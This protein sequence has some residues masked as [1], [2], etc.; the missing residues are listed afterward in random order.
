MPSLNALRALDAVAR[1]GSF[2]RAAD[3]LHVSSPAVQQLVRLLEEA[4]GQP[5]VISRNR[6]LSLSEAA[7]SASPLLRSGFES[8]ASAVGE[9]RSYA[10]P[11]GIKV[12]VEPSFAAGWLLYR[13]SDFQLLHPD[14]DVFIEAS[15][16]LA[17]LDRDA[18]IAIRYKTSENSHYISQQLFEDET[19]AVCAPALL[20]TVAHALS[21]SGNKSQA[22]PLIHF[23]SPRNIALQPD[24][25]TWLASAQI[26]L[27]IPPKGLRFSDYNMVLQSAIAGQGLALVSRPLVHDSIRSGLLAD[28]LSKGVKNGFGYYLMTSPVAEA[29]SEV[30]VFVKWLVEAASA[31]N[32]QPSEKL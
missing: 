24:W 16:R 25:K 22:L 28:A 29:R 31:C 21:S 20:S 7:A 5:L 11:K 26:Q 15:V 32:D 4:V 6:K 2:Q 3:E 12:S 14:I 30:S 9:M 27:D 18:D 8:I 13:L 10:R 1:H 17:D 23:E 19:I